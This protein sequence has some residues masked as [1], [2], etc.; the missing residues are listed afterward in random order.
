MSIS[1]RLDKVPESGIRRLFELAGKYKGVISLGIGEPDFDTPQHIKEYA[2]QG[3]DKGLTHYTPNNGLKMLR[4][5]IAVKLQRENQIEV[6]PDKNIIITIGGNEAFLLILSSFL[7]PG[8]E[9]LLLS[10]YFVTYGAAVTL[11]GG[12]V[13]EVGTFL[14]NG[15]RVAAEDLKKAVT[16]KTRC[17]I[18]NSPNNPTGAVLNRKDIEEIAEVAM[19][20]NLKVISDEVYEKFVYDGTKH[21]SM[22]SL[23][24]MYGN[25]ITVNSFSKTFAMTGWRIGYA[26]ADEVTIAKMVKMQM[27][28]ATC[29]IAFGQYA[30]AKALQDPRS[31]KATDEMQSICEDRRNY[32]YGRLKELKKFTVTKPKGAFY[33]FPKIDESDDKAFSDKLL[34]D[35]KVVAVPGSAF[36]RYGAQHLRL[37]YATSMKNLTEAM[38]RIAEFVAVRR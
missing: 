33:I 27:F 24:G 15:F 3:L 29:P 30:A 34:I 9:V 2:K 37:C 28:L 16:K 12:K 35:K 22:A 38:N 5:A 31:K 19:E 26:V 1:K 13:V 36:G 17:I 21:V 6:N 11:V 14:E 7:N 32:V 18:I 20:N 8:E 23:N 25:T 4:D 10:P